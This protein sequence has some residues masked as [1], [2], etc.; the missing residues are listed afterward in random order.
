MNKLFL[1]LAIATLFGLS[2]CSKEDILESGVTGTF[3]YE[4]TTSAAGIAP[5][6][7]T[8]CGLKPGEQKAIEAAGTL[9]SNGVSVRTVCRK[10]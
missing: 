8:Y 1:T 10:K 9:T 3:C 5:V 7:T 6:K 4:C 2:S